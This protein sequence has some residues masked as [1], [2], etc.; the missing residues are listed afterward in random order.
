MTSLSHRLQA[1]R[2]GHS[3]VSG[4]RIRSGDQGM[5]VDTG[6]INAPRVHYEQVVH[7]TMGIVCRHRPLVMK[8]V[9]FALAVFLVAFMFMAPRY[10]GE[11][12]I[13]L[14]FVRNENVAGE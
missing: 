7:D 5:F 6:T 13:Q 8:V 12:I 3:Q 14:D 9:V 10:T 11:A 1:S 4:T 2:S